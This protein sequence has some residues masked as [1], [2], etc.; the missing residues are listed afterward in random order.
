MAEEIRGKMIG[1]KYR[2]LSLLG[3][4]AMGMVYRAEQLDA[5]GQPLREVALKMVQPQFSRDPSFSRRFLRE[6][7]VAARLHS[8]HTVT[9]YD[10]GQAEQGQ[11][12]YAMELIQGPTLQEVLQRHG[13]LPVEHVVRIVGQVCEALAEAHS[14][15]EPIVHRDLKP[16]NIGK[17]KGLMAGWTSM[18]WVSSC[19]RC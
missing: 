2:L 11:L 12:Y 17:G 16:A 13:L 8:P 15:S 14:L 19:M 7:R 9:V 6:V 10:T 3:E 5:E 4:G 1:G 18:P